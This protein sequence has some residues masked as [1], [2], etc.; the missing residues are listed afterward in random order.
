MVSIRCKLIGMRNK[1]GILSAQAVQEL[2]II[3]ALIKDP[4]QIN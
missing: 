2:K 4:I 1:P 3:Q